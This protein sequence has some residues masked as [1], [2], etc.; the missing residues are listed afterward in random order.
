MDFQKAHGLTPDGLVGP[1]TYSR[2]FTNLEDIPK[3]KG[4][5]LCNGKLVYF[6]WPRVKI[7]LIKDECYKKSKKERLPTMVVTH[8]DV[9]LSADSCKKVLEKRNISTHFVIDNDGTI[10]QLADCNDITWHAGNRRVN[11]ASIGVD[12]SN[13]YYTKYQKTYVKRGHGERPVLKDS[14]V[15]GVKLKPHLGYYPKQIMAYKALL[16][17]LHEQYGITLTTPTK[18]GKLLTEVY[19]PAVAAKFNGIVCHYHLTRGK[20]DTAGLELDEILYQLK[21]YTNGSKD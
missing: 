21:E 11:N 19:K 7:D 13:A 18:N 5:I 10:V 14:V 12:F 4:R 2:A 3:T 20:I 8:W 9:C 16:E 6:D 17:F 15:H 1:M